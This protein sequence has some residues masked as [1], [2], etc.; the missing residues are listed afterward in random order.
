MLIFYG[1]LNAHSCTYISQCS[2]Y[3]AQCSVYIAQCSVYIGSCSML[4]QHSLH[5]AHAHV[6][7]PMI[8]YGAMVLHDVRS[9]LIVC[10]SMSSYI[11]HAHVHCSIMLIVGCL[12]PVVCLDMLL[13]VYTTHIAHK[14]LLP[15]HHI[16]ICWPYLAFALTKP[17]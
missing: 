6:C 8:M 11:T 16:I 1:W 12:M 3:I 9:M 7:C 5:I 17:L 4:A 14:H 10:Y 13:M 15:L 2:V